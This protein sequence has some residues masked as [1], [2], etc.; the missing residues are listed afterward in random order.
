[1]SRL[2]D[3]EDLPYEKELRYT[4]EEVADKIN[5]MEKI[6]REEYDKKELT[7]RETLNGAINQ[8]QEENTFYKNII[9]SILHI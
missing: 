7:I 5:Y 6:L 4:G 1:M 9:K 2:E 3:F 8:L